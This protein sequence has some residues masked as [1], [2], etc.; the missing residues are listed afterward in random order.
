ME[1]L[2]DE[3]FKCASQKEPRWALHDNC[4]CVLRWPH[5][6]NNEEFT[7]RCPLCRTGPAGCNKRLKQPCPKHSCCK[8][9]PKITEYLAKIY[10]DGQIYPARTKCCLECECKRFRFP[11]K[12][13]VECR[14]CEPYPERNP[15]DEGECPPWPIK[16]VATAHIYEYAHDL[17]L[18]N[19]DHHIFMA[20]LRDVHP[21][22]FIIRPWYQEVLV[23]RKPGCL[24]SLTVKFMPNRKCF[25]HKINYFDLFNPK[26]DLHFG[27]QVLELEHRYLTPRN[28]PTRKHVY[29]CDTFV[30]KIKP[31]PYLR[32]LRIKVYE[33]PVINEY[34]VVKKT[35]ENMRSHRDLGFTI[36][37]GRIMAV[38]HHSPAKCA[39]FKPDYHIIEV[40]GESTLNVPDSQI[41]RMMR[42]GINDNFCRETEVVVVPERVYKRISDPL[43]GIVHEVIPN[44]GF[45][46]GEW[47][48]VKPF[49]VKYVFLKVFLYI[50]HLPS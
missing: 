25:M 50:I 43:I 37:N 35:L 22:G 47:V 13:Q 17:G 40:N 1:F 23:T 8:A 26:V 39:G 16:D 9:A 30:I 4:V 20:E 19:E 2:D 27:D 44:K 3:P 10:R 29:E 28:C 36:Y 45:H 24:S 42:S 31:C 5:M 41:I 33:C 6:K 34:D 15:C 48:D 12:D 21:C 46:F 18:S 49:G 14:D 38:D 11:V 32:R 7:E